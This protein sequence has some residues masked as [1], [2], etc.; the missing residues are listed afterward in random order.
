MFVIMMPPPSG[1]S[2]DEGHFL[3][4][5]AAGAAFLVL[6]EQMPIGLHVYNL[7]FKC[8]GVITVAMKGV[9]AIES[10]QVLPVKLLFTPLLHHGIE[11][12]E[13]LHHSFHDEYPFDGLTKNL[14]Q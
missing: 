2:D 9:F 6:Q 3:E 5:I 12:T 10:L 1:F 13:L 8:A 11:G 4:G 14:G 7:G